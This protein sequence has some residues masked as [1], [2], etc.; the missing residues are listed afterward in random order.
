M[1]SA[2]VLVAGVGLAAFGAFMIVVSGAIGA[3]EGTGSDADFARAMVTT[4]LVAGVVALAVGAVA[5]AL[6]LIGMRRAERRRAAEAA[7]REDD[8]PGAGGPTGTA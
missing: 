3:P 1:R 4:A 6:G 8:D 7:A 5:A 2:V